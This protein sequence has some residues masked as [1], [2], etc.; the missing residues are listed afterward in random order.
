MVKRNRI[1]R[2]A[3]QNTFNQI[4]KEFNST[5]KSFTLASAVVRGF[6]GE[7]WF[8]R[9]VIPNR[10]K[11]GFLTIDETDA[12]TVDM[13]AYRIMM[14]AE[15]LYN[16]QHI[17]GFDECITKMRDGDIE[18]THAELDFGRMLYIHEFDFGTSSKAAL[19]AATMTL[20]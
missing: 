6:L 12:F 5:A 17:P 16:L 11:P 20:M 9:H 8:D 14:L 2:E 1:T 3:L 10:R 18:G 7:R 15:L 4:P 13:S 19:R